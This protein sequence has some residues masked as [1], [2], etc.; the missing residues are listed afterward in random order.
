M[1]LFSSFVNQ[2]LEWASFWP[3]QEMIKTHLNLLIWSGN[4][5][6][7]LRKKSAARVR[8]TPTAVALEITL[9]LSLKEATLNDCV[10]FLNTKFIV[11]QSWQNIKIGLWCRAWKVWE[12]T[13][14]RTAL[15]I[16]AEGVYRDSVSERSAGDLRWGVG[17]LAAPADKVR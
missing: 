2:G 8:E 4:T 13:H 1:K 15:A 7:F 9:F 11:A 5:L 16:V 14:V 12:K 3:V 10:N 6:D 17:L